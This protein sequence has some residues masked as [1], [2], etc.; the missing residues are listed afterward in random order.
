MAG[1]AGER[2][3]EMTQLV[4]ALRPSAPDIRGAWDPRL[5]RYALLLA[6]AGLALS[7]GET[8]TII[9]EALSEA[10]LAVSVF[11]AGTLALIYGLERL[12]K[13]D[14][15]LVLAR[16]QRWQVPAAAL[17]GAFPGCGGAIVIVTQF[18][19]GTVS[20]GSLVATLTATMGDAMFLLLAT[21]PRTGLGVLALG[22][23]VGT[24][25]G[26]LVDALH[27][28]RFLARRQ[29]AGQAGPACPVGETRVRPLDGLWLLLLL[30]GLVVGILAAFQI[31]ADS[32][33]GSFGS[34]QPSLW[35]GVGGAVLALA[36]WAGRP[37]AALLD[38][39]TSGR[40][41]SRVIADTNFITAWVVFAFLAYELG[42]HLTGIDLGT[43]FALWAPVVPL[44]AI[45][46]GWLPGCGPQ[47]VVTTLYLSGALPLSAQLGNAISNDGDALFP[48]LALAP[49][50]AALATL[51]STLPAILV[52]Y[53]TLLVF[54]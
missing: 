10:Y 18:T 50:A 24:L 13:R 27:G 26:W 17:L 25:S 47:I 23:V 8:R 53:T 46:V 2:S 20:F 7:S 32:L 16:L 42:V 49:K 4:A 43:L 12:F 11:V 1:E 29:V 15:G 52:A 6:I 22:I 45:L 9:A 14:L 39:G 38:D 41:E 48:A 40:T 37:N 34:L 30:P 28:P 19:R 31:E 51:Y 5:G 54:E 44:A 21:E 33:L 3:D 35:L 36:M